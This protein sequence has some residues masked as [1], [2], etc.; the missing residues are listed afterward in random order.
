MKHQR[1]ILF[2]LTFICVFQLSAQKRTLKRGENLYKTYSYAESIKKY[3]AITDKTIDIYRK[4]AE[5]YYNIGKLNKAEDN[6]KIVVENES[7]TADDIYSYAS[8]LSMNKK[9]KESENGCGSLIK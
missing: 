4:L 2:L 6:W 7:R 9:Y 1:I 5:S 8:V 3:E